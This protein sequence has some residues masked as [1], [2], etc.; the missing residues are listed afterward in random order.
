MAL[1]SRNHNTRYLIPK[2]FARINHLIEKFFALK[3]W[4]ERSID[5]EVKFAAVRIIK[6]Y[7]IFREW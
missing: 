7:F 3:L 2:A 1:P 6:F 5:L 4:E